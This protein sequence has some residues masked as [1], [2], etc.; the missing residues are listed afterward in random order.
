MDLREFSHFHLKTLRRSRGTCSGNKYQLAKI[1]ILGEPRDYELENKTNCTK[2]VVQTPDFSRTWKGSRKID[3]GTGLHRLSPGQ[4]KH[5]TLACDYKI[6]RVS[7]KCQVTFESAAKVTHTRSF[8][9]LIFLSVGGGGRLFHGLF[10]CIL[11]SCY[12]FRWRKWKMENVWV[13]MW[14]HHHYPFLRSFSGRHFNS[15][16]LH[17]LLLILFDDVTTCDSPTLWT[18]PAAFYLS[19]FWILDAEFRSARNLHMYLRTRCGPYL[20]ARRV[21]L[22]MSVCQLFA[23]GLIKHQASPN[24]FCLTSRG[25]NHCLSR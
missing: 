4:G 15:Q 8:P 9:Q 16:S 17:N 2:P 24:V 13:E 23:F 25:E 3:K 5:W 10:L 7:L 14:K 6:V 19:Q 20:L 1:K 18:W 21:L 11:I 12:K 22:L